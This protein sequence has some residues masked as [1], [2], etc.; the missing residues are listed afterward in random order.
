M[1]TTV[2]TPLPNLSLTIYY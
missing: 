1:N 2:I